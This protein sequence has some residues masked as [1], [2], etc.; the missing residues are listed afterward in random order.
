MKLVVDGASLKCSFGSSESSLGVLP[1]SPA[2]SGGKAVAAITDFAPGLNI[3][4]FGQCKTPSNPLVAAAT[5]AALGVLTPQACIPVTVAPWIP[6]N[7]T[8]VLHQ[9]PAVDEGCTLM[10]LWGGVIE[11][12][13]AKQEKLTGG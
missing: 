6:G 12:S 1:V 11:V 13:D 9:I 3:R 7:S 10:C 5:A 2:S 8:V 4:P